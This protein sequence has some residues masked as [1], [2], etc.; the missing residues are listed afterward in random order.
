MQVDPV[1]LLKPVPA[2]R[3]E[4]VERAAP[5]Q[6][7]GA[8]QIGADRRAGRVSPLQQPVEEVEVDQQAF[9][10]IDGEPAGPS[11]LGVAGVGKVA[12]AG[13]RVGAEPVAEDLHVVADP[14]RGERE[15][16]GDLVGGGAVRA[17]GEEGEQLGVEGFAAGDRGTVRADRNRAEQR[18]PGQVAAVGEPVPQISI[19][20]TSGRRE[21]S[22]S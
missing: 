10:L 3:A 12:A 8:V 16:G 13:A 4:L 21:P 9:D 1:A 17:E 14:G 18:E 7:E 6:P 20:I 5:D 19:K 15:G 2:V 11:G 22:T